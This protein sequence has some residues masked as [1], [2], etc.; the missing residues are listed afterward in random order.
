VTADTSGADTSH[1][2]RLERERAFHDD[3]FA[4]EHRQAAAKYYSV[5]TGRD[6]YDEMVADSASSGRTVLEYG[7]GT[8]SKAFDLARVGANVVGID[9][10][11]VGVAEAMSRSRREG[12]DARFVQMDAEQLASDSGAFD[13]VCGSGILHHLDLDRS[14]TE[15]RRVLKPGGVAIFY[16]PLGTNPVIN[17]YRRLTPS[18]RTPDEHPLVPGDF[19]LMRRRFRQIEIEYHTLLS[20]AGAVLVRVPRVGGFLVRA[21][22]RAD[23]L[24]LDSFRFAQ[25]FA[26]VAVVRMHA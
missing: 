10:S 23:R 19:E 20:L 16:E 3:R 18:M 5:D 13:V 12:L 2:D 4:H 24:L 17:L 6:R 15:I 26:W 8:G 25:R 9:I 21:L 7:C 22:Q 11:G 14:V 1:A